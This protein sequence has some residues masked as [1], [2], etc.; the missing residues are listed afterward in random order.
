MTGAI[1]LRVCVSIFHGEIHSVKFNK[2]TKVGKLTPTREV[3]LASAKFV[4]LVVDW[5]AW[6]RRFRVFSVG[7]IFIIFLGGKSPAECFFLPAF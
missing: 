6:V 7:G 5:L 2:A 4:K 1:L 3:G